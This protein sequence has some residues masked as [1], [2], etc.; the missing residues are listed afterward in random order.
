MHKHLTHNKFWP[1]YREFAEA[2]LGFLRD[3]VPKRWDEFRDSVTD[4][5]GAFQPSIRQKDRQ[6]RHPTCNF[7]RH[8]E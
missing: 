1:D 3:K 2:M 4:N 7:R 8:I 5:F 6:R